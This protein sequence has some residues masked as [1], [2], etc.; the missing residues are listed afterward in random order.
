MGSGRGDI[1]PP[2]RASYRLA[3]TPPTNQDGGLSRIPSR[4]ST[5]SAQQRLEIDELEAL[6]KEKIKTGYYEIKKRFKDN[7]PEQRG[8]V[9]R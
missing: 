7:D 1:P 4:L 9:S 8:N 6:L 2:S 3:P 5:A